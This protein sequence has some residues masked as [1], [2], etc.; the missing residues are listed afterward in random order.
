MV[1]E[2][3][4][5]MLPGCSEEPSE[6][7]LSQRMRLCPLWEQKRCSSCSRK[8]LDPGSGHRAVRLSGG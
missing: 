8:T 7:A 5:A 4:S 6:S 1:L 2:R 3:A